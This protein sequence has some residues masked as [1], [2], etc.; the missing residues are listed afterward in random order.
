MAAVGRRQL[1]RLARHALASFYLAKALIL[2]HNNQSMRPHRR[3]ADDN[4]IASR[5]YLDVHRQPWLG[6]TIARLL[7]H[8]FK[9][10]PNS[11]A[12]AAWHIEY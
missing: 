7:I 6:K 10:L 9:C 11:H 1:P 5:G 8:F 2:T 12:T 4:I 3:C